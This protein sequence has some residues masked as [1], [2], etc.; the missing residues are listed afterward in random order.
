MENISLVREER[1]EELDA[2]F[3]YTLFLKNF[4]FLFMM[5]FFASIFIFIYLFDH[6]LWHVGS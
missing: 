5:D 6:A 3:L 1:S 2:F 4:D